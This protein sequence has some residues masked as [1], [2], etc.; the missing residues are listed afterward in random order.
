MLANALANPAATKCN[1]ALLNVAAAPDQR[2]EF[3]GAGRPDPFRIP[4]R[5]AGATS[6]APSGILLPVQ[7]S[8]V[9]AIMRDD[10]PELIEAMEG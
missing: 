2:N 7:G 8:K 3:D 5:S 4:G 1:V 6:A 10:G 9:G